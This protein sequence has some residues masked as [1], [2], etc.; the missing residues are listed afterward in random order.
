MSDDNENEDM[1]RVTEA[2][3]SLSEF[4]DS[5]QIF[6]TRYEPAIEDGTV[7]VT[8]GIGNWFARY[9]QVRNWITKC[10]EETRMDARKD[11]E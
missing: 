4:F 11:S 6:C 9:G 7:T 3:E 5:V 10:K 2:L 8:K 1:K